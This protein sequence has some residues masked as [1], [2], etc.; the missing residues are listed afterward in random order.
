MKKRWVDIHF[1]VDADKVEPVVLFAFINEATK[2]YEGLK[3]TTLSMTDIW[4]D[5]DELL[6]VSQTEKEN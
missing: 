2:D 6:E 4:E 3:D 5:E 1:N